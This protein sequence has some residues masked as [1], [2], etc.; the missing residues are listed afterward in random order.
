MIT[1]IIL[2]CAQPPRAVPTPRERPPPEPV[3][4]PVPTRA[5]CPAVL[6]PVALADRSDPAQLRAAVRSPFGA[7]RTSFVRGH[8]HAG[9]DLVAP[10]ASSVHP[11]CAGHVVDI[12]LAFPHETVVIEH[13]VSGLGVRYTSYKHLTDVRVRVGDNVTADTVLG[14][15]F[16]AEEQATAAWRDTH[17]HFEWRHNI[18]DGGRASWTAMSLE[19]LE[20]YASDPMPLLLE[21]M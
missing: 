17:L 13:I 8:R 14:R 2:G 16:T 4:V 21:R 1:I 11:I 12:H 5:S 18:S 20:F 6:A 3:V 7:A 15:L 9:V 19:D 10:P